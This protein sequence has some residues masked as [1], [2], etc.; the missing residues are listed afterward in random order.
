M[1]TQA[2]EPFFIDDWWVSPSEG[3]LKRDTNV[4]HLEPKSMEMLVYFAEHQGE[5][6]TRDEFEKNVWHGAL[7]G[8]D[9]ITNTVIKLRKAFKDNARKPE[10]IVT[11]PKRGYQ[12]I[13]TVRYSE[14]SSLSSENGFEKLEEH[15]L[16]TR[17][18]LFALL[19]TLLLFGL[20][21]IWLSPLPLTDTVNSKQPTI[22][23]P[24]ISVLPFENLSNEPKQEY[25]AV[26]ITEDI[27]TALSR[28]SNLMVIS[29]SASYIFK[30]ENS[31]LQE[32]GNELKVDYILQGNIRQLGGLI[33][34]NVQLI[35][36]KTGVNS[37][38][39]QYDRQLT[40]LFAIQNEV[41]K[42]I[43]TFFNLQ[44]TN[45]EK[46]YLEHSATN[47]L[48]AYDSFQE[49]QK[50]SKNHTLENNKLARE[51]YRK[52][53]EL[54]PEY[55]RAYGALA[56]LLAQAFRRGWE[57][58]PRETLDR[59]LV[60]A[61]EGVN[62]DSTIP[63]THWTLGYVYLMRQE[64]DKAERAASQAIFVAPSYADGYGL[65]ALIN[66]NMGQPEKAIKYAK[67]GMRL[68]PYYTWDYLYNLGRAYY[69]L[70]RYEDATSALEKARERNENVIPIRL[71]LA[72]TYVK[73]G[74][75][76]DA[77]WEA[78]QVQMLNP[79]ET[80]THTKQSIPTLNSELKKSF[81]EDLRKA[82]LPE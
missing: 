77:E 48:L 49:G 65:L 25:L 4:I 62:L 40:D 21:M 14:N 70:G 68:N 15:H 64:F 9:A 26:G 31:E 46:Q 71:F 82:G 6:I 42:S 19:G 30:G 61:K 28:L 59:A 17:N 39:E 56:Y 45:N 41:T 57:D 58:A 16:N 1:Q 34:I 20:V 80:I 50:L 79:S 22:A 73:S 55:G 23:L 81:L 47:S 43:V 13:A 32:I 24:S 74:R 37:W 12:L 38:G 5:V 53:I 72:A 63:Q 69:T 36:T 54:D 10:Y 78:E 52:A 18:W 2:K 76:D 3:I 27:K 33:R 11:I 60:L 8:Y 29:S 51:S 35:N 67:K 7:I 75:Q 44:I 66:N